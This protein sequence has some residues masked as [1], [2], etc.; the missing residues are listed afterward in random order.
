MGLGPYPDFSLAEARGKAT[1][2]RK[3]RHE[4]IDPLNA[5]KAQRQ[6]QRV[7][8]TKGRTFRQCAV[9]F[10]EKNRAG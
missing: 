9:E 7:S 8:E 6:A 2:H 1:D 3:Q 5:K 4:G 10:I